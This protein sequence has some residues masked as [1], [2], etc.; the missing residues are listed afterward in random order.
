MA[1]HTDTFDGSSTDLTWT[2]A[3]G[4]ARPVT[5]GDG[6]A[7]IGGTSWEYAR[8][9]HNTDSTN[10]YAETRIDAGATGEVLLLLRATRNASGT[11]ANQTYFSAVLSLSANWMTFLEWAGAGAPVGSGPI[12]TPD[13]PVSVPSVP[14][15]FRFEAEGSTLRGYLGGTLVKTETRSGGASGTCG[16]M[17]LDARTGSSAVRF[18]EFRTGALSDPPAPIVNAGADAA[19]ALGG[20]FTRTAVESGG[21]PS[22]RTWSVLS[23]PAQTGATLATTAALTWTPAAI[24]TYV[25]RYTASNATGTAS[26]TVTV[27]VGAPPGP[28]A[29]R[30]LLAS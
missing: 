30:M 19:V 3:R 1:T 22:S 16:G 24:G 15:V 10:M 5:N 2:V 27:T 7:S 12:G 29:G 13:Q 6:T 21:A 23:G 9:E 14:F 20:A 4:S 28:E 17:G 26:D 25:L 18:G 11:T 8:A